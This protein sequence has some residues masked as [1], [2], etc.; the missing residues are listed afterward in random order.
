MDDFDREQ[1][2]RQQLRASQMELL[3]QVKQSVFFL[4]H[5]IMRIIGYVLLAGG[6]LSCQET[7]NVDMNAIDHEG[8]QIHALSDNISYSKKEVAD[9][10][11]EATGFAMANQ[12][13][14]FLFPS[15]AMLIGG[16]LLDRAKKRRLSAQPNPLPRGGA[17][18][19]GNKAS[20]ST[21]MK[22]RQP[23]IILYAGIILVVVVVPVVTTYWVRKSNSFQNAPMLLSAVQAFARDRAAA[24]QRPPP[25]VSLQELIRGGYLTTNDAKAFADMEVA[26]ST[27][28][29]DA[30]PQMIL[31]WARTP[32][33]RYTCLLADGS[34]QS[35]SGRCSSN[36][37]PPLAKA[38]QRTAKRRCARSQIQR[39]ASRGR[40]PQEHNETIRAEQA[41]RPCSCKTLKEPHRDLAPVYELA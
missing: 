27:Q 17:A 33:G 10:I 39:R 19:I 5:R 34:V 40:R 30:N 20:A 31:A 28:T 22:T 32:D 7:T 1:Q 41:K 15:F 3:H 9:A 6:F 38:V 23:L 12:S 29:D 24:G 16:V 35:L 14:K 4:E 37:I 26:F 11:H 2:A 21:N 8:S 36:F 13:L 25:K 18:P